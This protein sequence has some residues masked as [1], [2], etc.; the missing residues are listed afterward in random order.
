[1][2]PFFSSKRLPEFV[3]L[4]VV[5]AVLAAGSASASGLVECNTTDASKYQAKDALEKQLVGDGWKVRK[6]EIDEHCYEVYGTTPDGD[7]VEAFFNPV[8]FEKLL[9]ARR[10]EVLFR[11]DT[12]LE[13]MED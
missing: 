5:A 4:A 13:A 8:T 6:I 7:K 3:A 9:V 11:N 1:M 10:G 2:S 12:A